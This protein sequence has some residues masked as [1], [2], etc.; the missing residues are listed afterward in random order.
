MRLR[1]AKLRLADL[2]RAAAVAFATL[3]M[4]RPAPGQGGPEGG[5]SSDSGGPDRLAFLAVEARCETLAGPGKVR[6]VVHV[7]PQG[8]AWGWGDVVVI[9]APPFAPPLRTRAGL[10]DVVRNDES[11]V[12]FALA[13]AAIAD[14]AGAL[15]VRVRAVVCGE[16][17]C[18]PVAAE[19]EARVAVGVSAP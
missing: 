14:G 8:G 1:A 19:S 13:L 4:T 10:S 3:L 16:N 5:A 18:R 2:A 7:R 12:E 9:G 11:G 17:G 6:C 15:R